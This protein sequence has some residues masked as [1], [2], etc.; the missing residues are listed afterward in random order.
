MGGCLTFRGPWTENVG[1][2]S[3]PTIPQVFPSHGISC[4]LGMP[5]W[6]IRCFSEPAIT[7]QVWP[8][9]CSDSPRQGFSA[10][11]DEGSRYMGGV[12]RED[13]KREEEVTHWDPDKTSPISSLLSTSCSR[14][15]TILP[16]TK[17]VY[18]NFCRALL[19]LSYLGPRGFPR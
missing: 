15:E 1:S 19:T 6:G 3:T 12:W 14:S 11:G 5:L 13:E 18:F 9:A 10:R 17:V 16:V 8:G 7:P 2:G 4:A